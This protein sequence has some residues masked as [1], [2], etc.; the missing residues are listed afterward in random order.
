[1]PFPAPSPMS[2][3]RRRGVAQLAVGVVAVLLAAPFGVAQAGTVASSGQLS[4]LIE[5]QA[6]LAVAGATVQVAVPG[7][8]ATAATATTGTDGQYTVSLPAGH[9]DV[10]VEAGPASARVTAPVKDV[11]VDTDSHL[12]VVIAGRVI[13][14]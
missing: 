6:G 9:Y 12:N 13:D 7:T 2:R 3:R 14:P 1:M 8:G 5:D 11:T 4:G 10:V